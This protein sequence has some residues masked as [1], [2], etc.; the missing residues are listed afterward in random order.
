[1]VADELGLRPFVRPL[2]WAVTGVHPAR[3]GIGPVSATAR[4]QDVDLQI[5]VNALWAAG[6]D[7]VAINAIVSRVMPNQSFRDLE[8][9]NRSKA[10]VR[11]FA[12][13]ALGA[14]RHR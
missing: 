1:M 3:M 4:V 13:R 10:R 14:E 2:G 8:Q 5:V 6:A 7:A 12:L 9:V 11:D